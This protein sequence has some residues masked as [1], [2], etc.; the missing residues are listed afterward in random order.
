MLMTLVKLKAP[1][2]NW[3]G[4]SKAA[5]YLIILDRRMEEAEISSAKPLTK[6]IVSHLILRIFTSFKKVFARLD[7]SY[8]KV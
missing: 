1:D 5:P 3:G 2:H 4:H 6:S 8:T 7:A